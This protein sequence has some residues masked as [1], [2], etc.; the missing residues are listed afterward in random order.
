MGRSDRRHETKMTVMGL[1]LFSVTY[2]RRNDDVELS[3]GFCAG[4]YKFGEWC[5]GRVWYN[6]H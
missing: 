4:V 2:G 3:V 5:F 6:D 1:G